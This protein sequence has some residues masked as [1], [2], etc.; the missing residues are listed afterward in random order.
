MMISSTTTMSMGPAF[1][2]WAHLTTEYQKGLE[3]LHRGDTSGAKHMMRLAREIQ[4]LGL[5]CSDPLP[6][7]EPA[8]WCVSEMEAL[9]PPTAWPSVGQRFARIFATMRA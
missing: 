5:R 1:S 8:E 4:M 6:I 9:S 7:A 3:A 2:Q